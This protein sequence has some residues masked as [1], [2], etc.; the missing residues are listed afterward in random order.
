[1]TSIA[2]DPSREAARSSP[3]W[4][5]FRT[6]QILTIQI[7]IAGVLA[8]IGQHPLLLTAACTGGLLLV[9][10]AFARVRGRWLFTWLALAVRYATRRHTLPPHTTSADLLNFLAPDVAPTDDGCLVDPDGLITV[11]ELTEP[12]LAAPTPLPDVA[13]L[14]DHT[15]D[16]PH[17][18]L[19]LLVTV[20]RAPTAQRTAPPAFASD[21]GHLLDRLSAKP[22][23][24][25]RAAAASYRQL[26]GDHVLALRR[27]FV[28]LRVGR[29]PGWS[30][31]DLRP[32]MAAVARRVAKRIGP[33][34]RLDRDSA[35]ATVAELAQ[36]DGMAGVQEQWA[37][38][39]IGGLVQATYRMV[40]PNAAGAGHGRRTL[41]RLLGLPAAVTTIAV[42]GGRDPETQSGRW[43]A[44]RL[45]AETEDQ[46]ARADYALRQIAGAEHAVVQRLDGEHRLT[47]VETLPFGRH[48]RSLGQRSAQRESTPVQV[49][50]PSRARP[51]PRPRR[52]HPPREVVG[53]TVP[54][55]GLVLGYDRH[56]SPVVVRVFRP[57]GTQIVAVGGLRVAQVL[58]LRGLASGARVDVRTRRWAAWNAFAEEVGGKITVTP[59]AAPLRHR[60]TPHASPTASDGTPLQPCLTVL[61][62]TSTAPGPTQ[63]PTGATAPD[64]GRSAAGAARQ[65]ADRRHVLELDIPGQAPTATP[66]QPAP[67]RPRWQAVLT[68]RDELTD[69][70]AA[71]L[72]QADLVVLRRLRAAEAAV[73]QAALGLDDQTSELSQINGEM[74]TVVADGSLRWAVLATTPIERHLTTAT[75]NGIDA[76]HAVTRHGNSAQ[77]GD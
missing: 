8:T 65:G 60:A 56:G 34:R 77:G 23:T 3:Q 43:A 22:E 54:Q 6:G 41:D 21:G 72:A 19:E 64:E 58:A 61:D 48:S 73:V 52:H 1:M 59:D 46:L 75:P 24:P 9:V 7:A 4:I 44:V 14:L 71:L 5:G 11:F 40:L 62:V 76:S 18:T 69:H 66:S 67:P 29:P 50:P 30:D 74:V 51:S 25:G 57:E 17:A 39:A 10:A 2:V 68:V 49:H 12:V 16:P 26:T 27:T 37:F 70:D 38:V 45:A 35:L 33:H 20:A 36:H 31:G 32:T 47:V 13:T 63:E 55:A 42:G 15:A 28:V 53:G